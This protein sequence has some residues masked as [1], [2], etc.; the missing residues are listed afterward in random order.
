MKNT[1][2]T[3]VLKICRLCLDF[4]YNGAWH[5][6][7]PPSLKSKNPREKILVRFKT[8]PV[9]G[10]REITKIFGSVADK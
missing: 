4:E 2:N 3:E 9:C 7:E 10:A 8:C 6:E 1:N 5:F